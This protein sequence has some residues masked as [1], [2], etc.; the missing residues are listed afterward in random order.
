GKRANVLKELDLLRAARQSAVPPSP[1]LDEL[2]ALLKVVNERLWDIEDAIRK[3]E[4]TGQFEHRF[5]ALARSVYKNNDERSALKR[6]RNDIIHATAGS[7]IIGGVRSPSCPTFWN[8]GTRNITAK[9]IQRI[10]SAITDTIAACAQVAHS[11]LAR[12]VFSFQSSALSIT[13]AITRWPC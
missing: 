7:A 10:S 6:R 1:K 13:T 3:C 4:R 12:M 8:F 5:V 11:H 9:V 2:T